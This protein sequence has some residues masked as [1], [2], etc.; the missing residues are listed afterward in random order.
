MFFL[1]TIL[2]FSSVGGE[3]WQVQISIIA[4]TR[5]CILNMFPKPFYGFVVILAME[6]PV[7]GL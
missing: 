2:L 4:H 3:V 6:V 1:F 5:L 7:S